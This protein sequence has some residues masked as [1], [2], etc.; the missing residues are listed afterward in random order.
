MSSSTGPS[1]TVLPR[2]THGRRGLLASALAGV[3]LLG[4]TVVSDTETLDAAP[5]AMATPQYA[6]GRVLVRFEPGTPRVVR[7]GLRAQLQ[8][9]YQ[10]SL[11][12]THVHVWTVT[13]G[14]EPAAVAALGRNPHVE[15]AEQDVVRSGTAL[16][17]DPY[18]PTGNGSYYGGQWGIFRTRTPD[19][20]S[21]TG[22]G[23]SATV[24]AVVDSGI[25]ADHPDLRGQLV[26][27]RNV[28]DGSTSTDDTYGHGT[29]VAGVVAAATGNSVGIAGYCG[30]CRLMPVKV[31]A[32]GSAYDSNLAAGVAWAADHGARVV[33]LSFAGPG[34]SMT[35]GNAIS[36][37]RDKG[38]VV[39]AAAGNSGCDCPTYPASYPGV[40]SVGASSNA[41]G[42]ALQGYSNYGSWV[43]VA[44]PSGNLTTS[45][46]DPSTGTRWGWMPVGGTSMAAPVVAGVAGLLL[47][48]RPTASAADVAAALTSGADPVSGAHP[49][50]SGRIDAVYAL[51]A[52]TGAAAPATPSSTPPSTPS[53]SP[54]ATAAPSPTT[55]PTPTASPAPT[56]SASPAP[57]LSTQSF[58]ATLNRK[59]PT[60]SFVVTSTSTVSTSTTFGCPTL[61]VGIASG[62]VVLTGSTGPSVLRTDPVGASGAVTVTVSG[63]TKCSFSLT[64]TTT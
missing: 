61:S 51:A 20:W 13:P 15:Y 39:V 34:S 21:S 64:V 22:F 7:A 14:R 50:A 24:V 59:Q 55:S 56:A 5:V 28:L 12:D 44:A 27:G 4:A 26:P 60:R 46:T 16:P 30:G 58:S 47:S 19:A 48:A 29:E 9:R 45:L 52:V 53:P 17:D 63:S 11:P 10:Y 31:T 6:A 1:V 54:T 18:L 8:A 41:T 33:N 57:S 32:G 40:V 3:L 49:V 35:L 43:D 25:A 36:Y 62:A 38:V 23:S 42:D 2:A 37:A